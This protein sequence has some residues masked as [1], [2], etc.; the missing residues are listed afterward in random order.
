MFAW[1]PPGQGGRDVLRSD[2]PADEE[3]RRSVDIHMCVIELAKESSNVNDVPIREV[4]AVQ[5]AHCMEKRGWELQ[6]V[7]V[8]VTS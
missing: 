1:Q 3:Q 5:L 7:L 6:Y 8:L 2:I 4:R